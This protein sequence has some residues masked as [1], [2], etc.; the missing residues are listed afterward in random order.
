LSAPVEL[1]LAAVHQTHAR[2]H[3]CTHNVVWL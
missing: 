3:T 1:P 2:T